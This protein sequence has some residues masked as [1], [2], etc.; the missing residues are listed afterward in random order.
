L[1]RKAVYETVARRW[2][3]LGLDGAPPVLSDFHGE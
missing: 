2:R 3:E 1:L